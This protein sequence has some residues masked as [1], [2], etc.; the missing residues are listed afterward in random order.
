MGAPRVLSNAPSGAFKPCGALRG[1]SRPR[2]PAD[3]AAAVTV[4]A[5]PA[6]GRLRRSR[7]DRNDALLG[8]SPGRV[9]RCCDWDG[10]NVL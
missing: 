2:Q 7:H 8:V 4:A 10:K 3:G 1:S 9:L 5:A 6:L